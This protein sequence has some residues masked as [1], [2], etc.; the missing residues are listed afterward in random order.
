MNSV[1]L[2]LSGI[3]GLFLGGVFVLIN[4]YMFEDP[5]RTNGLDTTVYNGNKV[6]AWFLILFG[7][8]SL[9]VG[10]LELLK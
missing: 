4:H 2:I 8:G 7:S 9:L 1:E 6:A 3:L 10:I 5:R